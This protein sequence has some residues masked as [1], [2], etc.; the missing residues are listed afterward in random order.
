MVIEME[1]RANA[2]DF[3]RSLQLIRENRTKTKSENYAQF[4]GALPNIGDGLKFQK[5][6]RNEWN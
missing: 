6:V 5:A 1:K 2:T 3:K 4:F